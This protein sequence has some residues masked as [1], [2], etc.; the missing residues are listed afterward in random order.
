M[1]IPG[2]ALFALVLLHATPAQAYVGPG[3]GFAFVGSFF[4]LF[5]SFLLALLTILT[6]PLRWMLRAL[7]QKKRRSGKHVRRVVVLGLDGQDPELTTQ[8]MAE[9]ILP[10]FARLER[11]GAFRRLATTVPAE[12]PVA[13]SSFMTG[14]NPGKHRIFD[15]LV[16]DPKSM[17]PQ[18]SSSSVTPPPRTLNIG[19]RR[20]PLSRPRITSTR[21]AKTFWKTLGEYGVSSTVIRVPLT[22]PPERFNGLLLAAMCTP[23]LKGSQGTFCYYTSNSEEVV[24]LTSGVQLPL[25]L[26]DGTATGVIA[27]PENTLLKAGGEMTIPFR[28]VLT[29]KGR[30]DAVL[31]VNGARYSLLKGEYTPWVTI[32]FRPGLGMKVR[33][34]ARFLLLETTPHVRLYMTPLQIDPAR[35]ALPISHPFTYSVYL[36]GNQGTFATLGIAEDTSALNE[37]VIDKQAFVKQCTDIHREREAMFFDALEKTPKGAVVCVFDLAD[38]IQHM[39]LQYLDREHPGPGGDRDGEGD[40]VRE[41]YRELDALLGRVMDRLDE[42]GS[43]L[44]VVSDH[45]FKPFRRGV[46]L[47]AWLREHGYL[48][49]REGQDDADMLRGVD[50][51]GTRAYALGFGGIYLNTRG[52]ESA[53]IVAPGAEAEGLKKAIAEGLNALE[54]PA[55]GASVVR[56]VFDRDTVYGG[57]YV[58]QAPDLVVGFRAGYRAAWSAVTGGVG[59]AVF[60]DNL[61]PWGGDHNMH[62]AEVPG[63][64]FCNRGVER[65]GL[66]IQ[67]IA[68]TVLDLFGIPVPGNMDGCPIALHAAG[69]EGS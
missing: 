66:H 3:A 25:G 9:G 35:P 18:L 44:M 10:S 61:R 12:S 69:E 4:V 1:R 27:G 48:V 56:E 68:P 17:L 57:P 14:C 63:V 19:R 42:D 2:A 43:V 51:S 58:A 33:G 34:I 46:N 60:E 30:A 31:H 22:F 32:A 36:A 11:T 41:T 24:P 62:P 54:D 13:W 40:V 55:D 67:D 52:R 20:I 38:R 16:P 7:F 53:G 21:G 8:F 26:E 39:F 50:W 15:F 29:P 5:I 28:L 23:D 6:W 45:G 47:N 59:G 37:G 49:V 64:F 65:D